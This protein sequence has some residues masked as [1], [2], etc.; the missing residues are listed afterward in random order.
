M[1]WFSGMD[2]RWLAERPVALSTTVLSSSTL[3]ASAP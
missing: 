3:L 1:P 2:W